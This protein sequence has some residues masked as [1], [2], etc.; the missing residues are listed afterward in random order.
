MTTIKFPRLTNEAIAKYHR[1]AQF[2]IGPHTTHVQARRD[3]DRSWLPMY[4][5]VIDDWPATWWESISTNE[6]STRP[7]LDAPDDLVRGD[8]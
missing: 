4:Y 7:P 8:D 2:T 1:I 3:L 5:K 6:V